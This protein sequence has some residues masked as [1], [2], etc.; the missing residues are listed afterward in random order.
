MTSYTAP[1]ISIAT[2][3]YNQGRF[4]EQTLR[5]VLDQG[6]PNLEYIVMDG[7]STDGSVDIIR[8]YEHRLAYWRSER[9]RG[10]SDALKEAFALS[11]GEILGWV[12]SD[13][14]LLPGSLEHVG[15]QFAEH[16]DIDFLAGGFALIDEQGRVTWSLWPITPTK[17]RL[18]HVGFYVGQPACFWRRLLY[19]RVGGIDPSFNFA[20][21]GDLFLR[22]LSCSKSVS[23]TRLLA[24]FRSHPD[25]KSSN[26]QSVHL[27]EKRR[28]ADVWVPHGTSPLQTAWTRADW[29]IRTKL[30]R[31]PQLFRLWLEYK[32][33]RPWL[34][35][36]L[37]PEDLL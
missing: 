30:R 17:E 35:L 18:L 24:C 12:N 29:T 32:D 6:Y 31:A 10:Q 5:S 11:T 3:S 27:E 4:L 15:A 1:R 14:L 8:R 20:M 36:D 34:H 13:D 23:T 28:L 16:P 26:L 19:D 22:I 7:G 21:D 9:D 33:L 2:P 25:S 37:R